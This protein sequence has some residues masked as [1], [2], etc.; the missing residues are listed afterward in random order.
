MAKKIDHIN[1]LHDKF[2]H[3]KITEPERKELYDYYRDK[4]FVEGK[5]HRGM[6]NEF[7]ITSHP[8]YGKP[9]KNGHIRII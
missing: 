5:F 7:L 8:D 4:I 6:M 2:F 3:G 9:D 1:K